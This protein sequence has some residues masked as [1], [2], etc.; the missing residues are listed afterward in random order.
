MFHSIRTQVFALSFALSA[1]L[2]VSAAG[3]VAG[4]P[5]A[6]A[7]G[8]KVGIVYIQDAIYATND[9]KK[10]SEALQQRFG[11]RNNALKARNDEIEKLKSQL[12][13]QGDKLS[14]EERVKR[15]KEVSDKQKS[16]QRTYEDF[17]AEVQQ[18][19]QEITGRLGQKMLGV[20]DSYAKKNGYGIILDVSNPQTPVLWAS[21]GINISKDLVDAYNAANPVSGAPTAKP[22][23]GAVPK[24]AAPK[25]A[26]PAATPKKP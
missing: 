11:A 3:Q 23:A 17:Q 24:P 14:E 19:E 25:P 2:S 13:S 4:A 10:E 1:V 12:Q 8:T 5:S 9:G 7:A 26:G 22:A 16:L 18:A 6:S 20:M 15:V 21:E